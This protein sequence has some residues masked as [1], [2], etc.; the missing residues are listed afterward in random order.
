MWFKFLHKDKE[1]FVEATTEK[2]AIKRFF[3]NV[4][5]NKIPLEDLSV[6]I[7]IESDGN[8]TKVIATEMVLQAGGLFGPMRS[9]AMNAYRWVWE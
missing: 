8:P 4:K 2:E 5:E 3:K 1:T 9:K 7:L 6:I